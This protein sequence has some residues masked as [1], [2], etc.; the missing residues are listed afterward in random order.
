M[1]GEG[2]NKPVEIIGGGPAGMMAAIVCAREG[3]R[4][5]L[6]EKNGSLGRK[7]LATGNGRC[8]LSHTEVGLDNYNSGGR[9]LAAEAL[10]AFSPS[11]TLDFFRSLGVENRIDSQ[12]R[13]FPHSN[14]ASSVL[15][16]LEQEMARLGVEV[17]IRSEIISLQREANGW[18]VDQRGARHESRAVIM[19]CG[20]AAS[21]QFGSSGQGY[22][23]A[24]QLSHSIV[25]PAPAL[26]P[27]CL[28][29][30]W[31]H[32]LQGLR[33]DATLT[34]GGG[35]D[36]VA[37][38]DEVLFAHYGITG[39][40]ALRASRRLA[41][42]PTSGHLNFLPGTGQ[43]VALEKLRER[44]KCLAGRAAQYFLAGLLPEKLGRLL[45]AESGIDGPFNCRDLTDSDLSRLAGHISSWPLE[46]KGPRPFKEAQVTAGGIDCRQVFPSN[47]MSKKAPGLFFCGEVLDVDGDTGGYNLQWCW[48]SGYLA[49]KGAAEYLNRSGGS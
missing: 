21:P 22:Q 31:C 48:S 41:V 33:M 47:L 30:N 6:W 4:V 43:E 37:L 17:H 15:A 20:G 34:I 36:L 7:L 29:G 40:L 28:A 3:C 2:H 45:M 19:A 14:E 32:R 25:P 38:T 8:N 46:I 26:V 44:R 13:I 11:D 12:G 24:R 49:G 39:P 1:G 5:R 16:C 18:L 27:L 23:M 42:T 35:S 10:Q 9:Q